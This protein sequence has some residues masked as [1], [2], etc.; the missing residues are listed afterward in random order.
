MVRL[1]SSSVTMCL[2][3]ST[4]CL[5]LNTFVQLEPGNEGTYTCTVDCNVKLTEHM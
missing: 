3:M 5:Y 4:Y 2:L 1:T